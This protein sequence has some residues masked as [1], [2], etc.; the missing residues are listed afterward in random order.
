VLSARFKLLQSL[1]HLSHAD[2]LVLLTNALALRRQVALVLRL[3][4][5][6]LP[7]PYCLLFLLF[8]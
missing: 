6:H 4:K 8:L 3:L 7:H 1:I 5:P 2:G